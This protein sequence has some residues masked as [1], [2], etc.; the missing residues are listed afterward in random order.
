MQVLYWIGFVMLLVM[1]GPSASA[2]ANLVQNGG[3]E[4]YTNV[5]SMV[6]TKVFDAQP[7]YWMETGSGG[8]TFIGDQFG[9]YAASGTT[10]GETDFDPQVPYTAWLTAFDEGIYQS[11]STQP[12]TRYRVDLLLGQYAP[13][14]RPT[15]QATAF[16]GAGI[17]DPVLDGFSLVV[18]ASHYGDG[19]VTS[20][21]TWDFVAGGE[22]STILFTLG[23]NDSSKSEGVGIDGVLITAVPE[24]HV[25]MLLAI[26]LMSVLIRARRLGSPSSG[27]PVPPL[28]GGKGRR[29]AA[30]ELKCARRYPPGGSCR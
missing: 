13:E 21:Y 17:T 20:A 11:F 10:Y 8:H 25:W 24:P 14:I 12:G 29:S 18:D 28:A 22:T 7:V 6:D 19:H 27:G 26:G 15:L 2:S 3:F 4:A 23:A 16:D 30:P 1:G 5:S 9:L